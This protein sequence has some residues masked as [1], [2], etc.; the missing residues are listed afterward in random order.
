MGPGV[1][2]LSSLRI[3]VAEDN[4]INQRLMMMLL[5]AAGH[6]VEVVNNGEEAV[7][8]VRQGGFDIVLMDIQMPVL[9]GVGAARRIR[10]LPAPH[11]QIPILAL[12]ADAI[13]GAEDR[14]LTAGM[15]AYLA[16]P[17]TPATLQ[18]ALARLTGRI[19]EPVSAS[20]ASVPPALD[21]A[22]VAELRRIFTPAQFDSFIADALE[23]IPAR[24]QRLTDRIA[25]RDLPAAT[26]EA[27]DLVSL[28]GNCGGRHAS[29]LARA[30]EQTCRG[31]D[32]PT[33]LERYEAFAAAGTA[34]LAEL[35]ALRQLVE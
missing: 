34:V 21:R 4:K 10:A 26:R 16:K 33:A 6:Q 11:G 27:H 30:V 17:I 31:G 24:I 12:T 15:D 9:D 1:P 13:A 7:A 23:D 22:V 29:A 28:I 3:L 8:A 25:E 18:T 19:R 14:Y 35:A 20:L 32:H 5:A 2:E